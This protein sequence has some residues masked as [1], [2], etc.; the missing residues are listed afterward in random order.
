LENAIEEIA[1]TMAPILVEAGMPYSTEC[2]PRLA[3]GKKL[4]EQ[5]LE[6]LFGKR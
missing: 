1:L 5:V 2:R 6:L 4:D 3:F